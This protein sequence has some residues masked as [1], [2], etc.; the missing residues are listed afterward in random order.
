MFGFEQVGT[1]TDALDKANEATAE[2]KEKCTTQGSQLQSQLKQLHAEQESKQ[3]AFAELQLKFDELERSGGHKAVAEKEQMAREIEKLRAKVDDVNSEKGNLQNA[4]TVSNEDRQ[5]L[6]QQ[7]DSTRKTLKETDEKVKKMEAQLDL[8]ERE[9]ADLED[10]ERRKGQTG[11]ELGKALNKLTK[12]KEL[13]ESE[14]TQS[15]SVLTEEIETLKADRDSRLESLQQ[16]KEELEGRVMELEAEVARQK[17]ELE[18]LA[19]ELEDAESRCQQGVTVSEEQW[20]TKHRDQEEKHKRKV[21]ELHKASQ[22]EQEMMKHGFDQEKVVLQE[23]VKSLEKH[24]QELQDEMETKIQENEATLK[25]YET[26]M[27]ELEETHKNVRTC[28]LLGYV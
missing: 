6:D 17:E 22:R 26:A 16:L 10:R 14:L 12:D 13:K 24:M 27:D 11:D 5:R 20:R 2:W 4:L 15:I 18:R 9:K 3:Q 8:L 7:L 19:A 28:L 21:D 25:E 23:R 1:L